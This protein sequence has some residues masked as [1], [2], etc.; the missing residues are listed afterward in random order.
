MADHR[1]AG[2]TNVNRIERAAMERSADIHPLRDAVVGMVVVGAIACA[3]ALS[4][5]SAEPTPAPPRASLLK[6]QPAK[7]PPIG[8]CLPVEYVRCRDADTPVVRLPGSDREWAVRLLECWVDDAPGNRA[9]KAM[10]YA[11][12]VCRQ[13]KSLRLF[14]PFEQDGKPIKHVMDMFTFDRVLGYLYVSETRT[15][16][17]AVVERGY[18]TTTKPN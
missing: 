2:S 6:Y 8:I 7:C 11:D 17:E 15:L 4:F 5:G 18:A 14:I 13:A 1:P 9:T 16:N 12:S 10:V 3:V